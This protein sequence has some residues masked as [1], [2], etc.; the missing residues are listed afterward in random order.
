MEFSGARPDSPRAPLADA[1][2]LR[3]RATRFES[4]RPAVEVKPLPNQIHDLLEDAIIH[5]D[6]QPGTRLLPDD[7]AS[8]FGVSRIP[9]RE[10]LSSLQQA[11]WVEIR[12][13]YGAYV[14]VHSLN[15]LTDLFE[16]RAAVEAEIASLAA[17]RRTE[18]DL[19]SLRLI[20]QRSASAA[21][22]NDVEAAFRA[23][24]DFNVA[25]RLSCHNQ[26]LANL[27]LGL[28]KRAR[29]YFYPI[30]KTL[31]GDW[32]KRQAELVELIASGDAARAGQCGREHM[33][34]TGEDVTQL[35]NLAADG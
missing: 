13:R 9:V 6:I 25:V 34:R 23:S 27:S 35:L 10:A 21:T 31:A 11:G 14:C 33:Q 1:S 2:W 22:T 12:P 5:G 4:L 20:V 32:S 28:E 19:E 8:E 30:V 3:G 18:E 7:L 16:A 24:V 17:Q 26:V 29:F 15:E